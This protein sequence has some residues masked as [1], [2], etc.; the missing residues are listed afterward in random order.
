MDR[1]RFFAV[2]LALAPAFGFAQESKHKKGGGA[3]RPRGA[4]DAVAVGGLL[5]AGPRLRRRPAVRGAAQR[6]LF[7]SA[8][9][10]TDR[11]RARAPRRAPAARRNPGP[12]IPGRAA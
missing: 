6:R 10:A 4:V 7:V 9:A 11:S 5:R 8:A 1:R 2:P 3:A 12:L